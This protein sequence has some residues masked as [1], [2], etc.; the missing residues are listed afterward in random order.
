MIHVSRVNLCVP[1]QRNALNIIVQVVALA[2]QRLL[3]IDPVSLYVCCHHQ[4]SICTK[5]SIVFI[6]CSVHKKIS[7]HYRKG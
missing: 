7:S 5:Y 4:L 3:N 2:N 6:P 1:Y